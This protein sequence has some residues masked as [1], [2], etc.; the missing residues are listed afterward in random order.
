MGGGGGEVIKIDMQ[1]K[2][3]LKLKQLENLGRKFSQ[4]L[5]FPK[6][7]SMVKAYSDTY[8]RTPILQFPGVGWGGGLRQQFLT[9]NVCAGGS[10]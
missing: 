10:Q 9:E 6:C 7:T 2:Y 1:I 3:S 4:L 5:D 8:H